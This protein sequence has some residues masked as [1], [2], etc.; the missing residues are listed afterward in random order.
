MHPQ[1]NPKINRDSLIFTLIVM[2]FVAILFKAFHV[3]IL[4]SDFLQN[5]GNKRQIRSLEI[6]APRGEI[7]DRNENVLALSTPI[8]SIWVDPKV[9]SFYLDSQQQNMQ[10]NLDNLSVKEYGKR[11]CFNSQTR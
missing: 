4:E 11:W 5:E 8:D 9:L 6:P 3:Q 7:F 10:T 1:Q 2:L